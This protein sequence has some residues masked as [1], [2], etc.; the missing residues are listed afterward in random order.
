MNDVMRNTTSNG[1]VEVS[2]RDLTMTYPAKKK[3]SAVR[4]LDGI[5]FD[6]Y[7]GE[8]VCIVG[9]SGCGKSTILNILG[10]FLS[11]TSGVALVGGEPVTAPDPRRI[12]IFQETAA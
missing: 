4:V 6:V 9:P 8:F 11:Q 1:K 12:F 5:S 3:R 7:D 2:I 10:G